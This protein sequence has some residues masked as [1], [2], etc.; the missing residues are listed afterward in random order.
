MS[1]V[2]YDYFLRR[3]HLFAR[4]L[5]SPHAIWGPYSERGRLSSLERWT[6]A[7]AIVAALVLAAQVYL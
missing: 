7:A 6:I 4:R 5:H 1:P 3:T 2:R